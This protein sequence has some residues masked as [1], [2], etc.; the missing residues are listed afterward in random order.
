MS[1][2]ALLI[3]TA[4]SLLLAGIAVLPATT[5]DVSPLPTTVVFNRDI[6]PIL[7]DRCFTCHGP[8]AGQ[9]KAKLRLDSEEGAF[10]AR[11]KGVTIAKGKPEASLLWTRIIATDEDEKMPPAKTGKP[12]SAREKELLKLWIA[13]GAAWQGHWAYQQPAPRS[14]GG[15]LTE[16]VDRLI[17][18]RLKDAG[19][20]AV[21]EADRATLIR[22]LSL[23]ITGLPPTP[24]DIDAFVA[25]QSPQAW[26]KQVD[27]LLASPHYGERLAQFWLDLVRYAD[28]IGYHSDNARE[29]S[30]YRDYVI[31]AFTTDKPFDRFTR[32]QLAGDLLSDASVETRVASCYNMLLMTT[33]EGGAQSKEYI[34]KML[35]D[36]VRSVSGVWMGATVGCAECHDHK[37]DPYS[38]KDFYALGA[39]FADIKESGTGRRDPGLTVPNATFFPA[40]ARSAPAPAPP[41]APAP[42]TT[43]DQKDAADKKGA[44]DKKDAPPKDTTTCFVTVATAPRQVRVLPRGNWLDDS[45]PPIEPA[46]PHFLPIKAVSGRRPTRL[47]LAD[48][49][50]AKDNPLTARVFVNRVWKLLFGTGLAKNLDDF[51]A[52]GESPSHPELLDTLAVAFRD[53]G[54]QV[55]PLI[56]A[57]VLSETYR[58]SSRPSSAARAQDADNRLLARQ[59]RWR[60]DAEFVRDNALAISGLLVPRIGGPSVKPYQPAGYWD[61]MN[62][63]KR[64]WTADQGDSLY[65]RG[66]YTHWQRTFPHPVMIAFDAPSREETCAERPRS[67]I[68]QQALALLNEPAFVEAARGL[69]ERL[70]AAPGE[71]AVRL[72]TGFRLA[73]ARKPD[74]A[75]LRVLSDL[76][77]R[78]RAAFRA[79][80]AAAGRLLAVG[81]NPLPATPAPAEVAAWMSVARAMLNL[82]ET[83]TRN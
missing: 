64:T 34:A 30:P 35:A 26:T 83:V 50:L 79:D 53:G 40:D 38:A 52:Q 25:D 3:R 61:A 49:L 77:S 7:S 6:R 44:P 74:A 60:I 47:D 5:V 24:A 28:S 19:L 21:A 2:R 46:T 23:D 69:A 15:N 42:P 41:S 17:G 37:Y 4:A 27:R 76:L 10:A 75:E 65:R 62:F 29:V 48:W 31:K 11:E 55:K 72:A 43:P 56:R 12:L 51:G 54:W 67:N 20:T 16:A 45:G 81:A 66:L 73:T 57:V 58:R 13:Q 80:T 39:F 33:E 82:H 22:R 68:P 9:R 18:Q 59:G 14:T 70:L 1:L 71:D 8:D 78:H 36:R 32:E 63:P